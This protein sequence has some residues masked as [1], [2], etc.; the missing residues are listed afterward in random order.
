MPP[1][2][3]KKLPNGQWAT[4]SNSQAQPN[5]DS[6]IPETFEAS[7]EYSRAFAQF[8]QRTEQRLKSV[9]KYQDD[10]H[11]HFCKYQ[12]DTR[13]WVEG[14]AATL[15]AQDR[16]LASLGAEVKRLS[17]VIQ[18]LSRQVLVASPQRTR[19]GDN[20]AG[21][22]IRRLPETDGETPQDLENAVLGVFGDCSLN[23]QII[24]S[25]RRVGQRSPDR[26][27]LVLVQFISKEVKLGVKK[28]GW[29]LAGKSISLDH[30]LTPEQ[31]KQRAAQW[32]L[33]KAAKE[34]G[35]RWGWSNNEPWK[36]IVWAK[37]TP[38]A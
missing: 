21:L 37:R 28:L 12:D 35:S 22:I 1:K 11:S 14:T 8:Q 3:S 5:S 20:T 10:F 4:A 7:P 23:K 36:L 24:V 16:L 6:Q 30:A 38:T 19:E 13:V 17:A 25:I 9:E 27:R 34:A 2:G 18:D 26:P 29:K 31:L 33:L 15:T 32:P